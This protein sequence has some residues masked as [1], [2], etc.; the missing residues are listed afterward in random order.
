MTVISDEGGLVIV[1]PAENDFRTRVT[2]EGKQ[3]KI[4]RCHD[5]ATSFPKVASSPAAKDSKS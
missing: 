3:S 5:Y 1:T 4:D 2:T